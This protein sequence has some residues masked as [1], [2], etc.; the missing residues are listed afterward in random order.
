M[1][2]KVIIFVLVVALALSVES[3]KSSDETSGCTR[4]KSDGRNYCWTWCDGA[5]VGGEWCWTTK[6][7]HSQDRNYV[8]CSYNYECKPDWS[9]AGPCSL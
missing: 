3:L 6:S 4:S 9:C 7:G 1:N 5:G 2:T 8:E